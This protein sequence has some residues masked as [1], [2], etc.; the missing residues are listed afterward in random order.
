VVRDCT[1]TGQEPR[2]IA[3]VGYGKRMRSLVQ[4]LLG[5]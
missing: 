1:K 4:P 5:R 3:P 2:D